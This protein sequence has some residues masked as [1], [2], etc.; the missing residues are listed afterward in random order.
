MLIGGVNV[1][2][3]DSNN[4]NGE[5]VSGNLRSVGLLDGLWDTNNNFSG[6]KFYHRGF[7][8]DVTRLV[9]DLSTS[10]EMVQNIAQQK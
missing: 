5:I 1:F 7:E 2:V 8:Y 3:Y 4:R 10:E 6:W 9:A